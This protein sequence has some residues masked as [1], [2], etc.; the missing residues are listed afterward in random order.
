MSTELM[1]LYAVLGETRDYLEEHGEELAESQKSRLSI[2][3]HGCQSS[4]EDLDAL[5]LR[6]ESLSTQAQRSWDR[7]RFGLK[8]LSDV[9]QRLVSSTTLLTSFNTA[10]IKSVIS[11]LIY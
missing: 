10:L 2:L 1:S 7:V 8:D 4:L 9:R 6:Y 11:I 5:Y 3:M